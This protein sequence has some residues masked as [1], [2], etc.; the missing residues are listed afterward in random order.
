MEIKTR[1]DVYGNFY[2]AEIYIVRECYFAQGETEEE[3]VFKL[4]EHLVNIIP[5]LEN[6]IQIAQ[7][8]INTIK[9]LTNG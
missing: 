5:I 4:K 8:K 1:K 6:D 7:K 3:A 9:E 2:W